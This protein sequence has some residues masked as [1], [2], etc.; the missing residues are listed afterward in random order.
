MQLKLLQS[1]FLKSVHEQNDEEILPL[2]STTKIS[3]SGRMAI[4]RNNVALTLKGNL[5]L[6]YPAVEKLVGEDFF[7]FAAGKYIDKNYSTSGNLD[8]YGKNFPDFLSAMPELSKFPY[9]SD[10]AKLEWMLNA[11]YFA[12]DKIAANLNELSDLPPE[13]L[14]EVKFLFHPS[15]YMIQSEYPVD[16]IREFAISGGDGE[17]V[18]VNSGASYILIARP[19]LNIK[20]INLTESEYVFVDSLYGGDNFFDAYVKAS[21]LNENFIPLE[22]IKQISSLIVEIN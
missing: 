21:E 4:Y 6:K 10:V 1:A 5:A 11:A 9:I 18:D 22:A 8:D 12:G 3:A 16:K 2:V 13:K 17:V 7:N 14:A 15:C 20:I 19:E